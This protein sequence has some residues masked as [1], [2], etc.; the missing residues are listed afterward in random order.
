MQHAEAYAKQLIAEFMEKNKGEPSA[1]PDGS[2]AGRSTTDGE[3]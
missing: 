2:S 3:P 1:S